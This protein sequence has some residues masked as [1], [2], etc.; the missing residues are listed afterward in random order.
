[1]KKKSLILAIVMA[2]LLLLSACRAANSEKAAMD[3][4]HA[5]APSESYVPEMEMGVQQDGGFENG[6]LPDVGKDIYTNPNNKIIR[7]A[8][9]V[10]QTTEFDAAV[11]GLAQLTEANGGYYETAEVES[12]GYFDTYSRRAAYF[13]VRIPKENF[14]S[15]RN[16][17]GEIGHLY[18]IVEDAQDVGESY[19]D[20]EARLATLT[21]KRDR[22]L[23]LLEEA[24]EMEDIITL[25]DALADVLYEIDQHTATLRKY[26]SLISYSTFRI[27]MEEVVKIVEEPK[28]ED[29]FGVKLAASFKRGFER[30]AEN[31]EDFALWVARNLI[32]LVI[33]AAVVVV[34]V[35]FIRKRIRRFREER[36]VK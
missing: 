12:G 36:D 21:I 30:F 26:D 35:L 29:S 1:M 17:A 3:S 24:T 28:V 33:F 31:L 7:S 32:G 9:L 2:L 4:M 8:R 16:G 27:T 19:Y 25:E 5:I 23:A 15:F 10:I 34:I 22:L 14:I 18:S 13:V 6:Y 11:E 20:T